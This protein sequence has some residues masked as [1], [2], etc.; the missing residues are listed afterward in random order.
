MELI[1]PLPSGRVVE[2]QLRVQSAQADSAKGRQAAHADAVPAAS[3][4]RRAESL[5]P[6]CCC[7]RDA[8][9]L[10]QASDAAGHARARPGACTPL[11]RWPWRASHSP[12]QPWAPRAAAQATGDLPAPLKK[13]VTAFQMVPDPMQRY[14]QLLFYASKLK[15]LPAEHHTP[16]NKVPGCV[17]QAS[18]SAALLAS[19]PARPDPPASGQR[20]AC[21]RCTDLWLPPRL[22]RC[23]CCPRCRTAGCISRR[24]R[25]R[26]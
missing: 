21:T 6:A 16:E 9:R 24:T 17:S 5:S 15:A 25:T 4:A 13:I 12:S 1:I 20:A 18:A 23:G 14:K 2:Q 10:Q 26:S 11:R 7:A 8:A 19:R 3:L 22:R